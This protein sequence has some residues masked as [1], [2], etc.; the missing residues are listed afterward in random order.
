MEAFNQ[1]KK[2]ALARG[3]RS[4]L[5]ARVAA[6]CNLIGKERICRAP[7]SACCY[8]FANQYHHA[9]NLTASSFLI[10]TEQNQSD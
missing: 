1:A 5:E 4:I 6:P 9:T 2:E 3:L 10:A 8:F 7:R